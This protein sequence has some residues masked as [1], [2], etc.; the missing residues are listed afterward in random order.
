[1]GLSIFLEIKI[2]T[3]IC[4]AAC[5]LLAGC[6]LK[7]IR[8]DNDFVPQAGDI[9]FQDLDDGPFCEAIEKVTQGYEGSNFSHVAIVASTAGGNTE[10]LEASP[11]GVGLT[12]L[13]VFLARSLDSHQRPKVLVGRLKPEYRHLIET[14]LEE[15]LA[16]KG[17]PYDKIFDIQ[18][19]AYY[20][21]EIVYY[22][23]L[24]AQGGKP[25]FDLHPMT[26]VD[27][28]TGET[29]PAW[30]IYFEELDE[31]IPEGQ[32]GLNPGGISRS[33]VL[34]IVHAYGTPSVW[35]IE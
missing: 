11:G 6:S 5:L 35:R 14:A 18:N 2:T 9:L 12:S 19:D 1:M 10:V 20:C 23:F 29:F 13:T 15:M 17:K 27:P 8:S 28:D 7:H 25:L 31:P 24:K 26:F 4:L 30:K 21:S 16:L 33:S 3:R 32:P 22:G 34:S